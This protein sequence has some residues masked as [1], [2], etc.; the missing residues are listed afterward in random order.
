MATSKYSFTLGGEW[1][2]Q[3]PIPT[4][5]PR[6][7]ILGRR[8]LTRTP[9]TEHPL[10]NNIKG[11]SIASAHPGLAVA[12]AIKDSVDTAAAVQTS[13]NNLSDSQNTSEASSVLNTTLSEYNNENFAQHQEQVSNSTRQFETTNANRQF[14]SNSNA[15][16]LEASR[17][18]SE[19]SAYD[20]Q[21]QKD[22]NS[23]NNGNK[24]A[25][26]FGGILG[27]VGYMAYDAIKSSNK[28]TGSQHAQQNIINSNFNATSN[29]YTPVT[30]YG[31]F[32]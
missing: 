14:Q 13:N 27:T 6:V 25:S 24:L 26:T 17:F 18:Q 19:L 1:R 16:S 32:I 8:D 28:L 9:V 30:T 21:N 5:S 7:N 2:S 20:R 10:S 4:P 22:I 12:E 3:K 31:N 29:E 23:R 11:K 15:I